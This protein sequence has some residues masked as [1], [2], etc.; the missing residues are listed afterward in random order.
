MKIFNEKSNKIFGNFLTKVDE[1]NQTANFKNEIHNFN[2]L[3]K[4]IKADEEECFRILLSNY[5]E[6][7]ELLQKV[8]L[9]IGNHSNKTIELNLEILMNRIR[10]VNPNYF[11]NL[12]KS[13]EQLNGIFNNNSNYWSGILTCVIETIIFFLYL[14]N[15]FINK[16]L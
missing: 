5:G 4:G 6:N 10:K 16:C 12:I 1:D 15:R 13:K 9:E 7:T 2:I 3:V 8:F 14:E 11:D